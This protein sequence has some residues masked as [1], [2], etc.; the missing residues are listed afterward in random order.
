[1]V[2]HIVEA[3]GG[4]ALAT[5]G[6][7]PSIEFPGRHRATALEHHVLEE[8]G[9]ATFF[10]CFKQAAGAAP[11]IET[12]Q[13]GVAHGQADHLGAVVEVV[14]FRIAEP[15]QQGQGGS[16]GQDNMRGRICILLAAGPR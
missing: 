4:I 7:H 8:V 5:K 2:V 1:M 10:G 16:Q 14:V 11:E 15:R 3:R 12:G 13:W 6:L 9:H